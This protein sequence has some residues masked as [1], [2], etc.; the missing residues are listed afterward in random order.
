MPNEDETVQSDPLPAPPPDALPPA[1]APADPDDDWRAALPEDLRGTA[2]NMATPVDAVRVARD[3]RQKLSNAV[4][5][6]GPKAGAAEIADWRRRLGVPDGPDGY[7]YDPPGTV[8]DHL[9][10]AA[11]DPQ[12]RA[13]FLA[14]LHEAGATP[15]V[16]KAA[17]DWY[18]GRMAEVDSE[19][20]A[21]TAA[22]KRDASA[23]LQRDWGADYQTRITLAQR[24]INDYGGQEFADFLDETGL[25]NN[26]ALANAL[27]DLGALRAEDTMLSGN[28]PGERQT[29][30]DQARDLR[31][32]PDR[33]TNPDVDRQLREISQRLHGVG[34]GTL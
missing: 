19:M 13:G 29:L 7:A 34:E 25:G 28:P 30:E 8:P 31:N 5:M 14:A 12:T 21:K 15:N 9:R 22:E 18:W 32:R 27:A 2:R 11:K 24:A 26:P 4:T 33:W 23:A 17:L 6:P 10:L 16:A 20:E 3:L 1:S